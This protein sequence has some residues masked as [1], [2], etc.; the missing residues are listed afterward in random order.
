[1]KKNVTVVP[2]LH[3]ISHNVE[4][5]GSRVGV[6]V[7]FSA[8]NKLAGF[9]RKSC[10]LKNT[11]ISSFFVCKEWVYSILLSCGRRY[12]GKTGR[13]LND[14]LRE[15]SYNVFKVVSGHLGVHCRDCGCIPAFEGC[16]VVF[17]NKDSVTR[18]IIEARDIAR[19]G[20][21]CVS[22]PSLVLSDKVRQFLER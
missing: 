13:C 2:Y 8:P 19:L 6:E 3:G 16:Q 20:P 15:H 17:K 21:D 1:M 14:R 10:A 7:V 18:E 12:I 11:K 5:V 22:S 9:C 4:K